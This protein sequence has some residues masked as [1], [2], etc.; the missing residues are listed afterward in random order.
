HPTKPQDIV[1]IT[2]ELN[3]E[4]YCA[5]Y[6]WLKTTKFKNA[7][8]QFMIKEGLFVHQAKCAICKEY[9]REQGIINGCP[10]AFCFECILEWSKVSFLSTFLN[11]LY[12]VIMSFVSQELRHNRLEL[13][14]ALLLCFFLF[15]LDQ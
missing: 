10:H 3:S 4:I 14:V 15:V 7:V 11:V 2:F 12:K 9:I 13:E 8:D 1:V 5:S 6:E